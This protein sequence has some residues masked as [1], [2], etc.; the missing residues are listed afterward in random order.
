MKLKSIIVP[1]VAS[2]C[3][4]F[5]QTAVDLN[6][7]LRVTEGTGV[8]EYQV[9]WWGKSG[10]AYVL[11]SST[12]LLNWA[13][14]PQ[15][16]AGQGSQVSGV[17]FLMQ[18]DGDAAFWK[19]IYSAN[20]LTDPLSWDAD[21]DSVGLQDEL[22][23]GTDPFSWVS[24]G[25]SLPDDWELFH[26]GTTEVSET[27][28]ADGD[29]W[30]NLEEFVQ[31][32]NPLGLAN[33]LRDPELVVEGDFDFVNGVYHMI[34][35]HNL[36][37]S[38][39]PS[40]G[41]KGTVYYYI[42]CAHKPP[43]TRF[44]GV[45]QTGWTANIFFDD[46]GQGLYFNDP[47]LYDSVARAGRPILIENNGTFTIKMKRIFIDGSDRY[48]SPLV[49]QVIKVR[50]YRMNENPAQAL[51]VGLAYFN[52]GDSDF[53]VN[54]GQM[55][56]TQLRPTSP[57]WLINQV[58]GGQ[59]YESFV[60]DLTL[61]HFPVYTTKGSFQGYSINNAVFHFPFG[62]SFLLTHGW[63]AG[64]RFETAYTGPFQIYYANINTAE[65][66]TSPNDVPF[67]DRVD[68]GAGW[69]SLSGFVPI[70]AVSFYGIYKNSTTGRLGTQP[71]QGTYVGNGRISALP[72]IWNRN[73]ASSMVEP[74]I[75]IRMASQT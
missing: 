54:Q 38:V 34:D 48:E 49:T 62:T 30:T 36:E 65:I 31:G 50:P 28:D 73:L 7:G 44:D 15:A 9:N 74:A 67:N 40:A 43:F 71:G 20:P 5:S 53:Y 11:Q 57:G 75:L 64:D 37:I 39:E 13:Y 10:H 17:S 24:F 51:Y 56:T 19:L 12:D 58:G 70:N 16:Y 60:P 21:L 14:I 63:A 33:G 45:S 35:G 55:P 29:G 22:T 42:E 8:G 46:P 3:A 23:Q 52:L 61:N 72:M 27:D 68:L 2:A 41:V 18:N 26:F 1:F 25:N 47:N 4:A 69:M 6:A 32:S 66:T 59:R